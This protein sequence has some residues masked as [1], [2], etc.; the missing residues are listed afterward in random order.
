MKG[1]VS[2]GTEVSYELHDALL[3]YKRSGLH[4][5]DA[6]V[7]RHMVNKADAG[8]LVLGPGQAVSM[9]FVSDLMRALTGK[10]DSEILPENVL[11]H[12]YERIVWLVQPAV[13][14]MFYV[15]DRAPE[16][17]KLSGKRYPQ[18][19]LLFDVQGD[20]LRIRALRGSV[21]PNGKTPLL[22]RALLERQRQR[23]GLPG[24]YPHTRWR[25]S[26]F[27]AAMGDVILRERVHP[28]ELPR[29]P[30][31]PPQG[32]RRALARARR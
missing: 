4:G 24:R 13:R 14:A 25:R 18:P 15:A 10:L 32:L 28:S 8:V 1:Y 7:T 2:V 23:P 6:F 31:D 9:E 27:A 22:S 20:N 30:D 11:I 5:N 12:S 19:A 3:V 16:L 29:A 17:Q 21:R 26:L